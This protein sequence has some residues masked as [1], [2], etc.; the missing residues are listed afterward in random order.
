MQ[1]ILVAAVLVTKD[2]IYI[3][4]VVAVLVVVAI[5][6]DTLARLRENPTRILRG[7]IFEYW[8]ADAVS[9]R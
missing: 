6:F 4:D 9:G 5:V 3:E 8:I 2:I 1:D 7:L